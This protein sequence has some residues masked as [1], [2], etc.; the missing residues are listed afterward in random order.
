MNSKKIKCII[1]GSFRKHFDIIKDVSN[2]FTTAGIEVIAPEISKI[3]GE[4]NGFVH[5]ATDKSKDS[6]LTELLYLKK[7]SELGPEGFSYYVNP[8]GKLGTSASYELAID[9]LTN[10]RHLF[11]EE[12]ADHPAYV[13]KNSVWKPKELTDY[14]KEKGHYPLPVIPKDEKH[15][16]EMLQE[17]I[18]PGSVI[19]TGAIIVDYSSKRYRTGQEREVLLVQTHKWGDKFSIVGGKVRRNERLAEALKREI[20]EETGLES[21]IEESICTFDEIKGSG[22]FQLGTHRVFTDNVVKVG[23]RKVELNE[24]AEGYIWVPATISLQ[25]LDIEPNAKKTLEIYTQKHKRTK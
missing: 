6:R 24:E 14:I 21:K 19:A 15:I 8:D 10:T 23:R 1:H 20:L 7:L 25:E 9:Q 12:L 11:M 3:I 4:K 17:L 18:L 16:H 22:Y 13:P 2:L 5:L